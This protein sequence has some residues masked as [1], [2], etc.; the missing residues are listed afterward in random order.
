VG[1]PPDA[2]PPRCDPSEAL[3]AQLLVVRERVLAALELRLAP[4]QPRRGEQL[5]RWL[6][7]RRAELVADPGWIELRFDRRDVDT[8]IRRAGLDLD[9]DWLPALGVVVKF[10]YV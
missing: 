5:L 2:E 6:L 7:E 3:D 4:L 9:P 1:L 8:A 10:V